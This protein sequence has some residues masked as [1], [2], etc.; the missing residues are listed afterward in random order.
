M[1]P[2]P[3]KIRKQFK[4]EKCYC[5]P[6]AGKERHHALQYAGKQVNELFAIIPLCTECHRGNSGTIY[7]E[8]KEKCELHAIKEGFGEL[9]VK[10]PKFN[11][12]Q[13]LL[14][15]NKK[16]GERTKENKI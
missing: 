13:R 1:R 12:E 3:D 9:I 8:V 4:Q 14:Y 2:I 11:W 15:L 6:S 16:Y 10:Y 7:P 5:C